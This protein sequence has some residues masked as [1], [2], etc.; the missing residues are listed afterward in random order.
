MGIDLESVFQH[1]KANTIKFLDKYAPGLSGL[2][3]SIIERDLIR[4]YKEYDE[5]KKRKQGMTEEEAKDETELLKQIEE[6]SAKDVDFMASFE[7]TKYYP[8][9]E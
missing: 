3:Y 8:A 5:E 6:E 1:L 7:H 9:R 2:F 4:I